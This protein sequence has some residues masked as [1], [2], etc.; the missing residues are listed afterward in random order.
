MQIF[1]EGFRQTIRQ[2]FHEDAVVIVV[3]AL[4]FLREFFG[5]DSRGYH[6]RADVIVFA[7]GAFTRRDKIRERPVGFAFAFFALLT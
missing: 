2:R 7:A 3:F 1:R 5:A 4:I 6:K